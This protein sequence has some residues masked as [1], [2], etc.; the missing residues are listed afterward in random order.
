MQRIVRFAPR[1][2]KPASSYIRFLRKTWNRDQHS[3]ILTKDFL[4]ALKSCFEFPLVQR[5]ITHPWCAEAEPALG[6][7]NK[8]EVTLT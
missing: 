8:P 1:E 5:T 3:R 7:G 2:M 4:F 6:P